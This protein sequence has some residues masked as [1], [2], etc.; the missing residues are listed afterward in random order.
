MPMRLL[1]TISSTHFCCISYVLSLIPSF[2]YGVLWIVSLMANDHKLWLIPQC[3]VTCYGHN[4]NLYNNKVEILYWKM[5]WFNQE[6]ER[7]KHN[8][9]NVDWFPE[10]KDG[11]MFYSLPHVG[12]K[13]LIYCYWCIVSTSNATLHRGDRFSFTKSC[14]FLLNLAQNFKTTY[15]V[16]FCMSAL[17]IKQMRK[18]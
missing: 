17:F 1:H 4:H 6:D 8:L 14:L 10:W 3:V 16:T 12:T 7:V 2:C 5:S 13:L 18:S 11:A 9:L 15:R